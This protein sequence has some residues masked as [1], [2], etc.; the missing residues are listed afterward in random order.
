MAPSHPLMIPT[1]M[2]YL[3]RS[4]YHLLTVSDDCMFI[5]FVVIQSNFFLLRNIY[6]FFNVQFMVALIQRSI[7]I[8]SGMLY[9]L[10]W[11]VIPL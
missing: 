2:S 6:L 11:V 10:K 4:P 5:L 7:L 1:N 9:T 3:F 8:D